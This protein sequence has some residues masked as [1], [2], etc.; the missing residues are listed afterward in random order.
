MSFYSHELMRK[1]ADIF[2]EDWGLYMETE[3]EKSEAGFFS[4]LIT[5]GKTKA[6]ARNEVLLAMYNDIVDDAENKLTRYLAEKNRA[7]S[8]PF[9]FSR[10]KKTLLTLLLPP[11]VTEEFESDVDYRREEKRNL[12]QLMNLIGA[13][14]K[15]CVNRLRRLSPSTPR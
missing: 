14:V 12:I 6:Q 4:F 15:R 2:G 13:H 11:P 8:Q 9:T 5:R 1:Y 3:G 7:R 10:L